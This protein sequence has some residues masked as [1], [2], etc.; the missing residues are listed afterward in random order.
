M[1]KKAKKDIRVKATASIWALS[2][3]MLGICIPLVALTNSGVM[4]PIAVLSG[5]TVATVAV[6]FSSEQQMGNTSI[7][8]SSMKQLEERIANLETIVSSEEWDLK[9][10]ESKD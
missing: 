1:G 10:L 7:S 6:W 9:Q 5:A 4:L 8:G 3:G 2:T